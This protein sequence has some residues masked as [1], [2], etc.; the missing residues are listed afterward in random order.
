MAPTATGSRRCSSRRHRT[1]AEA[2]LVAEGAVVDAGADPRPAARTWLERRRCP[3]G[4]G[5]P[6]DYVDT[7][8]HSARPESD[9]HVPRHQRGGDPLERR[10]R[11]TSRAT[12]PWYFRTIADRAGPPLREYMP[13]REWMGYHG[14]AELVADGDAMWQEGAARGDLAA[15]AGRSRGVEA[16]ALTDPGGLGAHRVLV[17][18]KDA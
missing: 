16:A 9:A 5:R 2:D 7:A 17:L 6:P 18:R 4:G 12:S 8:V 14:I 10:A 1:A 13:Q 11:R 3:G 15:I